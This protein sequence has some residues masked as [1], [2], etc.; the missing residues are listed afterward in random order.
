MSIRERPLARPVVVELVAEELLSV[1][2]LPAG[3]GWAIKTQWH[4][5]Q[6]DG[7]YAVEWRDHAPN[8]QDSAIINGML[9]GLVA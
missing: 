2:I 9:D 6:P 7:T 5:P 1:Q 8:A 4:V 3:D